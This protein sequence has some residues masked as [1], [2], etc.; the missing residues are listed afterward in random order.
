MNAS[1]FGCGAGHELAIT[2]AKVGWELT[3][4]SELT[5][6]EDKCRQVLS[7]L[8]GRAEIKSL[9]HI[10]NCDVPVFVPNNWEVLPETEQLPNRVRGLVKF[11]P[12]KIILH[13]ANGQKGA[14]CIVGNELRLELAKERVYTAHILDYLLRPENQH[15][16][17]EEW[18]GKAIFFWGTIYRDSGD[19]CVRC[20]YWFGGRWCW[21]CFWLV[22][23]FRVGDPAA[24]SAS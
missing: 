20:L 17:P 23:D 11:D 16:I 10:I 24:V 14:K 7:F 15:L 4:F 5:Q 22:F 19:L 8:R 2:A 21:G 1:E 9:E 3:D 12:K 13:L 6:S 18:K